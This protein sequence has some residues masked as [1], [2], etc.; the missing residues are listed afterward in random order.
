MATCQWR[1]TFTRRR[2]LARYPDRRPHDM[3]AP[4][5][6]PDETL[7]RVLRT[8]NMDGISVMAIAGFLALASASMGDWYGA[9]IG[10][11]VAA[12][13]AIEL[14]GAGLLRAGDS[15]GM[16]WILASQPYLLMVLFGYCVQRAIAYDAVMATQALDSA[17]RFLGGAD[18]VRQ[19]DISLAQTG[20]T[21]AEAVHQ[22]Y[23]RGYGVLAFTATIFQGGMALYYWRRRDAVRVAV[24]GEEIE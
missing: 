19:F 17:M 11:L 9:G 16:N 6:L 5:L 23:L 20:R 13:G 10:L 12:A 18:A 8:A 14:H 21:K 15:R 4:P 7:A 2:G 24:D 3:K 22:L 1:F